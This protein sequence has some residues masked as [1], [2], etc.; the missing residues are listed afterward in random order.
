ML[1]LLYS[2]PPSRHVPG[3][4]KSVLVTLFPP[5]SSKNKGN[6]VCR[7]KVHLPGG[8]EREDDKIHD[9]NKG[10]RAVV[11]EQQLLQC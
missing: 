2:T 8:G 1:F 7:Q 6:A 3:A 10:V 9:S 4:G 5:G 11:V